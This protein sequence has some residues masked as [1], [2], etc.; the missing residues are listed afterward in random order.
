MVLILAG[1]AAQS[2][3]I[4]TTHFTRKL[5]AAGKEG[6]IIRS[7]NY[8]GKNIIIITAN[9][10]IG[11]LYGSF[12]F[13]RLLQ[14]QQPISNLN[15]ISSPSL[16]LRLLNHW[17]NLNRYVERGYAGISI[18]NWHTLPDYIDP[19]YKDYARANASIGINGVSLTNVNANAMVLTK[20]YLEKVRGIGQCVSSLWHQSLPHCPIQRTHR[21]W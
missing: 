12:H 5:A 13:L 17:D 1:T 8:Q 2:P 21:N 3:V 18:W 20:P 14:T 15:I 9:N 11:V 16:Q 10:D 7:V 4:S 6:F 19:R